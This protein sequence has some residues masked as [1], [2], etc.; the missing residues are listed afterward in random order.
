MTKICKKFKKAKLTLQPALKSRLPFRWKKLK[1]IPWEHIYTRSR[2]YT[3]GNY[4]SS[5][6]ASPSKKKNKSNA[7]FQAAWFAL[8]LADLCRSIIDVYVRTLVGSYVS[9]RLAGKMCLFLSYQ[10]RPTTL[11]A[12]EASVS[13]E[14]SCCDHSDHFIIIFNFF[15]FF[16]LSLLFQNHI[17]LKT[18]GTRMRKKQTSAKAHFFSF[19]TQ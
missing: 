4:I 19:I 13:F 12:W 14:A 3:G 2:K 6:F 15:N 1:G 9:H 5:K 7:V 16:Y 10:C 8:P 17:C 11:P 18:F